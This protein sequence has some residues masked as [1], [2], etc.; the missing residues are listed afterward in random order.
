MFI[1]VEVTTME[2]TKVTKTFSLFY[3]T[4]HHLEN[5]TSCP[6]SIRRRRI[7]GV[8]FNINPPARSERLDIDLHSISNRTCDDVNNALLRHLNFTLHNIRQL[9]ASPDFSRVEH[10]VILKGLIIAKRRARKGYRN[11]FEHAYLADLCNEISVLQT[12]GQ[13]LKTD[14]N[15]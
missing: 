5:W 2:K 11:K 6:P 9:F 7:E 13:E 14:F 12:S 1:D 15:F 4:R 3:Q 8:M 10:S